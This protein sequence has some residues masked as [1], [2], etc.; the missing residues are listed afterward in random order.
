MRWSGGGHTEDW[1]G[2]RSPGL[3]KRML[4][5]YIIIMQYRLYTYPY[6]VSPM[7]RR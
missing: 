1:P 5:H 7:V 2:E 3:P 4:K 6:R